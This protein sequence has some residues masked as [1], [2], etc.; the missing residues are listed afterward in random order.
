MKFLGL[1]VASTILV[2]AGCDP[3]TEHAGGA[4]RDAA[5]EGGVHRT[6]AG[7]TG[8][9]GVGDSH[10]AGSGGAA[11]GHGGSGGGSHGDPDDASIDAS[12]TTLDDAGFVAEPLVDAGTG[13]VGPGPES[14]LSAASAGLPASGL[15]LWLRADHGVYKTVVNRVCA[16]VD[17]SGHGNVLRDAVNPPLWAAT[18]LGNKAAIHFD[19]PSTYLTTAGVLGIAATS[20]RT[21]VAVIQL[22][23]TTARF[24]AVQQGQTGSPGT[25]LNLDANTFQ[26]AG[27]REGVYA[28]NNAYD[29]PLAT[30]TSPRIHVFTIS[31]MVPGT[32]VLSAIHYR[33]NGTTQSLTRTPAGLG[34]GNLEDFSNADFTLVGAGLDAIVAEV[35]VYDRALSMSE[36]ASTEAA[37]KTRY[38][39]P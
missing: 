13:C 15:V 38:A 17:Q 35:L 28:T 29:A 34:N 9:G 22:V 18:G 36:R 16:W 23:N 21:F 32:A 5:T 39:I 3:S 27:S 2:L 19:A 20:G 1:A 37:L 11:A 4:T 33:V 10:T 14:L 7:P 26:T 24:Q 30:S 6:D 8:S 12:E 31:T 25:Y